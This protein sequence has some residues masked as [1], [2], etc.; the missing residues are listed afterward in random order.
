M[1]AMVIYDSQFGHT[2]QIARAIADGIKRATADAPEV[3]LLKI[4]NVRPDQLAGLDVL[5]VGSPTQRFSSTTAMRDFLKGIPKKAL[6]GVSVAGFD[7]RL[8]EEELHSHGAMLGKLVDWFGYAAPRISEGL[9]KRGA[10][11]AMPPEGFYVGGTEGP[12]L[13]GELERAADWARQILAK[14]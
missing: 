7:T 6:A 14:R 5:V 1:K 8:T 3:D 13:E 10:R 4:G 11:V 12:L 9:E 2:E